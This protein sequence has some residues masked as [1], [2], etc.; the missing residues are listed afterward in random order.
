V[1][2]PE[3]YNLIFGAWGR[4]W[5]YNEFFEQWEETEG[6][7]A[8]NRNLKKGYCE[9]VPGSVTLTGC[10]IR[11]YCFYDIDSYQWFPYYPNSHIPNLYYAVWGIKR[12]TT[13][14]FGKLYDDANKNS[15]LCYPN[16]FNDNITIR[17]NNPQ[18]AITRVGIYDILGRHV[19]TLTK[20]HYSN[21]AVFSWDGKDENNNSVKS[22]IY[23]IKINYGTD[24]D[25]KRI[26]YLK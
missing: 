19:K 17:V 15:S 23:F 3:K 14:E 1:P 26:T 22:G 24:Q 4:R 16:P 18:E 5:Y 12:E 13:P 6:W 25:I 21:R 9:V 8:S 20:E 2:F 11:T 10:R 7:S